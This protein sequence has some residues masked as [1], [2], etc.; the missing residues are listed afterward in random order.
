[1]A[2]PSSPSGN[3]ARILILIGLVLDIVFEVVLLLYAALIAVAS[4]GFALLLAGFSVVGFVWVLLVYLFS[5]LRVR[6]RRWD[7]A[8]AP[9]LVFA[10][11]SLITLAII[12]GILFLVAYVKLGDALRE[13]PAAPAWGTPT[14]PTAPAPLASAAAPTRYCTY[15]GRADTSG[16]QYCQSCGAPFG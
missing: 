13:S 8:R 15:C 12:P 1:M 6:E 16:G 10:I 3:T 4:P 5:Y 11:L 14:A 2:A 7:D 9:T